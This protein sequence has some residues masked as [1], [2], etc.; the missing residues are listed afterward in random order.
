MYNILHFK[1]YLLLFT[2]LFLWLSSA[3]P[4]A[5]ATTALFNEGI[6]LI[7]HPQEASLE[8]DNLAYMEWYRNTYLP[9]TSPSG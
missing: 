3:V 2:S 8:G 7:P 4:A 6:Y 5:G 9:T 1:N